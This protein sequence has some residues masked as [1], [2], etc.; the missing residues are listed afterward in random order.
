MKCYPVEP[1]LGT[2]CMTVSI[3]SSTRSIFN[4]THQKRPP[5]RARRAA[6]PIAIPTIAPVLSPED[7]EPSFASEESSE[8]GVA[9]VADVVLEVEVA[10][11]LVTV[12]VAVWARLSIEVLTSAGRVSPG[13]NT[14]AASCMGLSTISSI[15]GKACRCS[16]YPSEFDLRLNGMICVRIDGAQ[17]C[18]GD[19]TSGGTAV[20]ERWRGRV[21][22]QIPSGELSF[23]SLHLHDRQL[24][25]LH[26]HRGH[27]VRPAT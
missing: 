10:S 22:S 7:F 3:H 12:I 13:V 27:L 17:H 25:H 4:R 18:P 1:L 14:Y 5:A 24:G 15:Q 16:T 21:D 20:E 23:L 26:C 2:Y 6:P 9:S 8:V 19:T 11:E